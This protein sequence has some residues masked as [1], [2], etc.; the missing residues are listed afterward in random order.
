MGG[1]DLSTSGAGTPE[2]QFRGYCRTALTN[3]GDFE[4]PMDVASSDEELHEDFLSGEELASAPEIA[5]TEPDDS[6]VLKDPH[7][8]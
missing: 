8:R 4:E 7:H 1:S 3:R 5:P 6:E 2:T